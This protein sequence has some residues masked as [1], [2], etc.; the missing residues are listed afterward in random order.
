MKISALPNDKNNIR[1]GYNKQLHE[2]LHEKLE[3]KR[4]NSAMAHQLIE[5]DYFA[6]ELKTKSCAL[7]KRKKSAQ[8]TIKI[9]WIY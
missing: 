2:K 6:L 4:K 1:F 5:A 8:K 9:L 7:K 3:H